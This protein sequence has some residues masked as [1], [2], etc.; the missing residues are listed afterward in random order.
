M[1]NI[2]MNITF[3]PLVESHFPLLLKWLEAPH[4]KAWWDQDV[5]WTEELIVKKFGSYVDGYKIQNGETKKIEAFIIN[6]DSKPIGYI[7]LYDAHAFPRNTT[8][9]DLPKSLAAIDILIGDT[10]CIGKNVGS[11]VMILF[12]EQYCA[13]LY[14]YTFV[15]PDISNITAI[16]SYTKAG[17]KQIKTNDLSKEIWMIK[18]N[19]AKV[20]SSQ[21]AVHYSWGNDCDGWRLKSRGNF[22]VIEEQMPPKTSEVNHLHEQTE[23]FFYCLDGILQIDLEK[24]K[25][26]LNKNDSLCIRAGLAHKVSNQSDQIVRFLVVSSPILSNDRVNL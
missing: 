1:T 18:E 9:I 3:E 6:L 2:K 15:D 14:E 10:D 7:Q 4:V 16:K 13:P 12:S 26:I 17:F 21:N 23:Q 11:D 5:R 8:L 20:V 19:I 24:S 22:N 25:H